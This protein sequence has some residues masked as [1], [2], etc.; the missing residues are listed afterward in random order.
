MGL[1]VLAGLFGGTGCDRKA[2]RIGRVYIAGKT[3]PAA[4]AKPPQKAVGPRD[5]DEPD[6][7]YQNVVVPILG[8]RG[9]ASGHCHGTLRGGGFQLL[10]G[11]R[12]DRQDYKE[13]LARIDRKSPA[14]SELLLKSTGKV[15]HNGGRN[16]TEDSCDYKR[17]V[18]WIGERPDIECTDVPPLDP[19][20]FAREVAPAL[21]AMGC[22]SCHGETPQARVR[23]DLSALYREPLRLDDA[24]RSLAATNP[25]P[26]MTWM[27]S[28][29]RA[30]DAADG[31][32]TTKIDPRSCAYRRLYGFLAGSPELGCAIP[33][34][35]PVRGDETL[36]ELEP[37]AK[38]VLP[39]ISKRGC[40]DMSCHGGGAGGMT[41]FGLQ[42]KGSTGLHEYL[43]LMAR[44][45]DLGHPEKSTF[46]QTVR[47]ELAHG[48]G[49][50]L[51]GAKDCI[52]QM[53]VSW[54]SRK[55]VRPCPAPTVPPY[56]R[57][58]KEIQPVLDRMTCSQRRCHGENIKAFRLVPNAQDERSLRANYLTTLKEID[59][60][61]MPFSGVQLRMREP[62]A[63]DVVGAWIMKQPRPNCV[64]RDPDPRLFPRLKD[65]D[66][67]PVK[68]PAV[69][70]GA[71]RSQKT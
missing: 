69:V 37:F 10:G 49:L 65:D 70:P 2:S 42:A 1:L 52:D 18:A 58:V 44:V 56:D 50:R 41:L 12:R 25:T 43:A 6:E 61:F 26:Y 30:A 20:R 9:C 48:G 29:I 28:V 54:L 31:K 5:P 35:G 24:R 57:F 60:D 66:M 27:S 4:P 53:V 7:R 23:F 14:Q 59:L 45:E 3:A 13:V 17:L 8:R 34:D 11:D 51:G 39:A 67:G 47:N 63:Y 64:L 15:Q 62:C 55:V 36:P 16:L 33:A 71:P 46:L 40:F 21:K 19:A 38:Y 68:H 22:V 32:H